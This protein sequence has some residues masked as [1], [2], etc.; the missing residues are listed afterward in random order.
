MRV[1]LSCATPIS[2]SARQHVLACVLVRT[3]G[4]WPLGFFNAWH[5]AFCRSNDKPDEKPAEAAEASSAGGPESLPSTPSLAVTPPDS[6]SPSPAAFAAER[7]TSFPLR[8]PGSDLAHDEAL[9]LPGPPD[10]AL[11]PP[12]YVGLESRQESLSSEPSAA[13]G[14]VWRPVGAIHKRAEKERTRCALLLF[15]DAP[16]GLCSSCHIFRLRLHPPFLTI[17]LP[18]PFTAAAA[19]RHSPLASFKPAPLHQSPRLQADIDR[20]TATS[21]GR[22]RAT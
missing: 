5:C 7:I 11:L 22:S 12:E 13:R 15:C 4:D 8:A 18:H 17:P 21:C 16:R 20:R 2:T 9:N 14:A 3:A 6:P 10:P 1:D 19:C